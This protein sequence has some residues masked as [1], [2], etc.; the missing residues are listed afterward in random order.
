MT[1]GIRGFQKG[2]LNPSA[3]P[4]RKEQIRLQQTGKVYTEEHKAKISASMKKALEDPILREKWRKNATGRKLTQETKDK[5]R[6]A[7]NNRPKSVKQLKAKLDKVFSL[8]I[9]TRDSELNA[10]G[11]AGY[12]ITCSN[13]VPATG[14]RSG[15]A[16]HF[17]SR[18]FNTTRFDEKNVHLQCAKCNMWGAGEQYKY[19]LAID[20]LYG[21]GTAEQLHIKAQEVKKFNVEELQELI[22]YYN[23][24]TKELD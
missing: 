2:S 11:R 6:M 23:Q 1:K 4:V 15:Q 10:E 14:I 19:S 12:C 16:G 5:I 24:K 20:R 8:Y 7:H 17:I 22:T 18:R 21:A 13:F 9:R 3:N